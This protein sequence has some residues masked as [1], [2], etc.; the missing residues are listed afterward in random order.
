MEFERTKLKHL[1]VADCIKH[2][3]ARWLNALGVV[4]LYR[5]GTSIT[6]KQTPPDV[7]HGSI[8]QQFE[9]S[10]E[11]IL[12]YPRKNFLLPSAVL[13]PGESYDAARW[14]WRTYLLTNQASVLGGISTCSE[15]EMVFISDSLHDRIIITDRSGGVLDY[16]GHA[17]CVS[18]AMSGLTCW[19]IHCCQ[20]H[21]VLIVAVSFA[22]QWY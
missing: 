4:E 13:F 14:C 21:F 6:S 12:C 19:G 11:T 20:V 5:A 9:H 15:E 18:F 1:L 22:A 2:F 8:N 10:Y 7:Q 17:P 3:R 16:V